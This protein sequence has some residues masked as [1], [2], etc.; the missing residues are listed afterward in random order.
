MT[1]V[2]PKIHKTPTS[3]NFLSLF[4]KTPWPSQPLKINRNK[5]TPDALDPSTTVSTILASAPSCS[6][7]AVTAN[8]TVL[9]NDL[10]SHQHCCKTKSSKSSKL[11][12]LSTSH[13]CEPDSVGTSLSIA[14]QWSLQKSILEIP[15]IPRK[16]RKSARGGGIGNVNLGDDDSGNGGVGS[17]DRS[18]KGATTRGRVK[19]E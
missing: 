6:H 19:G 17:G 14:T 10:I 7:H 4:V 18:E 8:N 2:Q 15:K 9:N 11:S 3:H 12:K 16:K 5:T 1:A 13:P